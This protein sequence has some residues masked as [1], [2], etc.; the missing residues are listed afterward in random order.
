MARNPARAPS[1]PRRD[2]VRAAP[3]RREDARDVRTAILEATERLLGE[4][5]LD[6]ITVFDVIAAAGV[7]RATFYLYFESKNA[8]V[9]TLAE[10]VTAR[11]YADLWQ[12][13]ITGVEAPSEALLTRHFVETMALWREHRA[14]LM[15]AA[16]AWRADPDAFY[17][18]GAMWTRYVEDATAYIERAREAGL[19]PAGLDAGALAATLIWLD[20]S[21]FYLAFTG[22]SPE[23]RDDALLAATLAGVWMRAIYGPAPFA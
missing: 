16:G 14:V 5:Q 11:I 19:A 23:L 7:S 17:Q 12:P 6:E 3:A 15:A 9:A 18:W 13:F 20:E 4:R 10:E 21:A 22:G 1:R 8:A 2:R